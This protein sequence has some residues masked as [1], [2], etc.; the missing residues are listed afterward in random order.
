MLGSIALPHLIFQQVFSVGLVI[1][2]GCRWVIKLVS[3]W[4]WFNRPSQELAQAID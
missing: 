1:F 4:L 2:R 3:Q